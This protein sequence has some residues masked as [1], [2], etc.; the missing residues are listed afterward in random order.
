MPGNE[1]EEL[2][3]EISEA[4]SSTGLSDFILGFLS[5]LSGDY[6]NRTSFVQFLFTFLIK[7]TTK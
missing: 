6:K 3:E 4:M 2:D 7:L 5:V 1:D